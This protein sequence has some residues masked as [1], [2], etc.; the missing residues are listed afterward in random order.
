MNEPMKAPNGHGLWFAIHELLPA[1][2]LTLLAFAVPAT[3]AAQDSTSV[4]VIPI[5]QSPDPS[6]QSQE[7]LKIDHNSRVSLEF[8][9]ISLPPNAKA[10]SARL[11]LFSSDAVTALL[12]IKVTVRTNWRSP[13]WTQ[14]PF[15]ETTL[16]TD[17]KGRADLPAQTVSPF[18]KEIST[19]KGTAVGGGKTF[20]LDLTSITDSAATSEWYPIKSGESK[21]RPRLIVEYELIDRPAVNQSDGLPAVQSQKGFLP[22]PLPFS[23]TTQK[24]PAAYSYT[25]AFYKN[26]VFLM[27]DSGGKKLLALDPLGNQVWQM[28]LDKEAPGQHLLVSQSGRLYIIGNDKILYTDLDPKNPASLPAKLTMV[29]PERGLNPTVAPSL[30]SNGNLYFV[31]GH[32]IYGLNADFKELWRVATATVRASRLTVDPDGEFV[33]LLTQ[34]EGLVTINA[35][36]GEV[37]STEFKTTS[38]T[39]AVLYAPVVVRYLGDSEGNG[40]ADK[41]YVAANGG[42]EGMLELFDNFNSSKTKLD[43][44]E[45]IRAGLNWPPLKGLWSQPIA[46]QL[47]VGTPGK[48]NADKKIYAVMVAGIG[49]KWR[50]ALEEIGWLNNEKKTAVCAAYKPGDNKCDDG[51]A[52]GDKSY[53]ANGGNLTSDKLAGRFVWNGSGAIGLY[54]FGLPAPFSSLLVANQTSGI[55][56]ESRLYFGTD[57]T[58]Y[59]NDARNG[60]D[61][62]ATPVLRAIIPQYTLKGDSAAEIISPTHLRIDGEVSKATTLKAGG[63]VLFGTGFTVKKGSSLTVTIGGSGK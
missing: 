34:K 36:T 26:L 33:Y 23:Y 11:S 63:S 13:T 28:P 38:D 50:G 60:T 61:I 21:Y 6:G 12:T 15:G 16:S 48:A 30:G 47:S 46:D 39:N 35:Q 17:F 5:A 4:T 22:S 31:S 54:A 42:N 41:I 40:A 57:G 9:G 18:L 14:E 51:F 19:D 20:S 10:T 32:E 44:K 7:P 58:L 8:Q 62:V 37:C 25:P 52:V 43:C 49:D 59:T 1:V 27:T 56:G 55:S 2:F 45:K 53:L 3:L 24:F 29:N